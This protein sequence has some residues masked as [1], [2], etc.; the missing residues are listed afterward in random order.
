MNIERCE[1]ASSSVKRRP[2]ISIW[3]TASTA[4]PSGEGFLRRCLI[5]S[6][7]YSASSI[8]A[9]MPSWVMPSTPSSRP[10]KRFT[11]SLSMSASSSGKPLAMH[12]TL[13]EMRWP[14][15]L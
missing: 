1:P 6:A 4:L 2:P 13:T 8:M 10:K 11:F 7:K 14:T 12:A 3:S 9:A 5:R 15:S